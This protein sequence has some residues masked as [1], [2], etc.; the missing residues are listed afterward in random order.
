MRRMGY[1]FGIAGMWLKRRTR[2]GKRCWDCHRETPHGRV[3]GLNSTP[4]AKVPVLGS[5]VPEW[6]K[7]LNISIV[8]DIFK[9]KVNAV[10]PGMQAAFV[11]LGLERTGFLHASDLATARPKLA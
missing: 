3:K 8:G 11:E 4:H 2:N 10:L 1:H 9:G 7:D 5:P 6:L